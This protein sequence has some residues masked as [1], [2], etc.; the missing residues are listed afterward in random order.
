MGKGPRA[1]KAALRLNA[2]DIPC[3]PL[4]GE[5]FAA[6]VQAVGR[7]WGRE[8]TSR[9]IRA[10][11]LNGFAPTVVTWEDEAARMTWFGK[12]AY[13]EQV[14]E[15]MGLEMR[16]LGSRS[17]VGTMDEWLRVLR[18]A[19]REGDLVVVDGWLSFRPGE[20]G[21]V[22]QVCDDG[23]ILAASTN[24]RD[25]NTV[26]DVY[27]AWA[28]SGTREPTTG[29][30]CERA[31]LHRAAEA[32][33]GK[34]CDDPSVLRGVKAMDR[35]SAQFACV[36]FCPN[37]GPRSCA[38]PCLAPLERGFRFTAEYLAES[39]PQ[40]PERS[41]P[42]IVKAIARYRRMGELL[43]TG[44]HGR[45]EERFAGFMGD[46]EGQTRFVERV[47]KPARSELDSAAD[48][49]EAAAEAMVE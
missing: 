22:T 15:A 34:A 31:T 43:G 21:A 28:V 33:R 2:E 39:A 17:T 26:D 44:F 4:D 35:L 19:L 40:Y 37:C 38:Q 32:I 13:L 20:W 8:L 11:S 45:E 23:T 48:A 42:H 7:H 16:K 46:A 9:A 29:L 27:H 36:P 18:E 3:N 25:D 10:L 14:A 1:L 12:G 5:S 30:A 47:L 41:R 24:G 49:L 6:V